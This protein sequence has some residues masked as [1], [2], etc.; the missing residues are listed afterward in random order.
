MIDAYLYAIGLILFF[1]PYA[2]GFNLAY[3]TLRAR[4]LRCRAPAPNDSY[5]DDAREN[6]KRGH[7]S[8]L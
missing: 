3:D 1:L 5:L 6:Y 8:L 2:L 7:A 4:Y